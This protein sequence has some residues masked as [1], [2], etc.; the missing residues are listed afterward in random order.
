MKPNISGIIRFLC[1][2]AFVPIAARLSA[3]EAKRDAGLTKEES[4]PRFFLLRKDTPLAQVAVDFNKQCEDLFQAFHI[5][6]LE[7]RE[8]LNALS[9]GSYYYI[10]PFNG[11]QELLQRA[12]EDSLRTQKLPK[13]ASLMMMLSNDGLKGMPDH[14]FVFIFLTLRTDPESVDLPPDQANNKASKEM[15]ARMVRLPVRLAPRDDTTKH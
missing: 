6:P 1:V 12:C 8:L 2:C 9:I 11:H 4:K 5:Q 7:T 13:A 15:L 3:D 10:L 14:R